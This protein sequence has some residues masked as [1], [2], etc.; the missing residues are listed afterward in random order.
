[1]APVHHPTVRHGLLEDED[2]V[3]E[4][5]PG[6]LPLLLPC[7]ARWMYRLR[8][9][10]LH[11]VR[12]AKWGFINSEPTTPCSVTMQNTAA[13]RTELSLWSYACS[14]GEGERRHYLEGPS[15]PGRE[16]L[17]TARAMLASTSS[18]CLAGQLHQCR[19]AATRANETF[20]HRAD[21]LSEQGKFTQ[22]FLS[23]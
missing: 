1:M 7:C 2:A 14:Q 15:N 21:Y 10:N 3:L 4:G 22:V 5:E 9:F 16:A 23:L 20:S 19:L 12:E 6:V 17:G 8:S 11:P 18:V 13:F